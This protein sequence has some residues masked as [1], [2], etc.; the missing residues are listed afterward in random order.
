MYILPACHSHQLKEVQEAVNQHHHLSNTLQ[1][2]YVKSVTQFAQIWDPTGKHF[3]TT[4][5]FAPIA[6]NL[7]LNYP[8]DQN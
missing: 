7:S 8:C 2:L 3:L 1:K 5:I 6:K 4:I